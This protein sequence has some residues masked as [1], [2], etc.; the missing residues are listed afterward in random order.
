MLQK[1]FREFFLNSI[2]DF[3]WRQW[4]CLGVL[5]YARSEDKWIIDPEALLIFSIEIARYE[6]RLFDEIIDWL[7]INGE[8]IDV[9]RVKGILRNKENETKRMMSSVSAILMHEMR[10]HKRKWQALSKLSNL[11]KNIHK[12]ILFKTKDSKPYPVIG[13]EDPVFKT[14]GF[15]RSLLKPSK[16]SQTVNFKTFATIRFLLRSLFGIGSR[17]ECILYLLTHEAGHPAKV[18]GA[19]GISVRGTQ[20]ALIELSKSNLILTR[21]RGKKKIEYW[22]S[23][24]K[25]WEFLLDINIE[26]NNPPVWLNW[27]SLYTAL[28]NVWEVLNEVKKT[29]SDYMR[30]SKLRQ[31]ME[32]ISLEFYES[33]LDLTPVP[34]KNIRP[35][36]YEEEFQNFI[37]KVIGA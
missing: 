17:A 7:I 12:E 18:A 30:S 32:T 37:L 36:K 29:K 3:L 31:A 16:K 35:E 19:I 27:I 21:I 8:W 6:P 26:E 33:E 2:L 25:W 11:K 24:K 20:D 15:S 1:D 22:L 9:Q 23:Q 5:G 34:D 28:I 14:Y 13:K 10:S 4:S